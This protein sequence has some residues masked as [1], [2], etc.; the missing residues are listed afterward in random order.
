MS[1]FHR[2][3]SGI[4]APPARNLRT[5]ATNHTHRMLWICP[6]HLPPYSFEQSSS[7]ISRF[8]TSILANSQCFPC[9]MQM[10]MKMKSYSAGSTGRYLTLVAGLLPPLLCGSCSC[11]LKRCSSSIRGSS[12]SLTVLHACKRY[13]YSQTIATH[14]RV[15]AGLSP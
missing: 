3:S 14:W 9:G 13:G 8:C 5:E 7:C 11:W 12:L 10:G 4:A 1:I 6:R 15:D 2:G